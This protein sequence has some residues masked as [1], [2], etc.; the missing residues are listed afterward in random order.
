M[1]YNALVLSVFKPIGLTSF[2]VV[3]RVR[4]LLGYKKVGHAGTLDPPASGVLI[5]LCGAA[6]SPATQTTVV[7]PHRWSAERVAILARRHGTGSEVDR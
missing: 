3:R 5:V 4:S 2:D 6:T 7:L 1:A